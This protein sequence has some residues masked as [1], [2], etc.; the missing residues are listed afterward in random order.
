MKVKAIE[1]FTPT[2][3]FRF[4]FGHSLASR[5]SSTNLIVKVTLDDGTIGFGEGVPRSYVTGEDIDTAGSAVRDIYAKHFLG[6]EFAEAK[7]A[8]EFLQAKFDELGLNT[9]RAGS[10]FCAL[11]LALLD[12]VTRADNISISQLFGGA[13]Q[14]QI[15]YDGVVPFAKRSKLALI[16]YF[17]KFYGF[18]TIKIKV[19]KSLDDNIELLKLARKILGPDI[20]L[21]VDANAIWSLDEALQAAEAFTPFS[22][23]SIEQPLA[24]TDLPGL[25]YLVANISQ[26]VVVD[27]SLCTYSD[28]EQL[29]FAKACGGFNIRLSKNGGI[30]ASL[31]IR[32]LARKNG[33]NCHLGAQVGESGIITAAG[34]IFACVN[35]PFANYEGADNFFLLKEDLT[36]E[37]LT[38]GLGGFGNLVEGIGLGVSVKE[39]A[40]ARL[41][42]DREILPVTASV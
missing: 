13:K 35:E 10:S 7:H 27:E 32:E 5:D 36:K 20:C 31:K 42:K 14:R 28:A 1:I 12:A 11:E 30:L 41:Q 9:K 39:N 33:I 29:V 22:V 6:Q 18:Q 16:L 2:L 34:R 3:P 4:A 37:N 38:V 23:A 40:I 21:R 25:S 15:R 8:V 19:G 26:E 24:A 17:Y